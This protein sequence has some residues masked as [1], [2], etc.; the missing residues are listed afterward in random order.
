MDDSHHHHHQAPAGG[1]AG[2]GPSDDVRSAHVFTGYPQHH[3]YPS[4]ASNSSG[5]MPPMSHHQGGHDGGHP[6]HG[7]H[8]SSA[9][10]AAASSSGR[11]QSRDLDNPAGLFPD[12]P[13]DKKRKF[14]L[15]E[16]NKRNC[17]LRVRVTLE[18]VDTKEIPDSFRK[19]SSVFPRS[20]FPREM[21][22]PPPSATG[23]RFFQD[24]LSDNEAED[25]NEAMEV[26]GGRTGRSRG[27]NTRSD[28]V[29][30]KVPLAG[31]AEGEV[32]IPRTRRAARQSEVKLNDLGYRMAW[33]QSRVFAGRTVFL[34]KALDNYRTKT[35]TAIET[36][37]G[38]DAEIDPSHY[39]MRPGKRRWTERMRRSEKPEDDE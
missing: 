16:D 13:A 24:D 11:R 1:P 36:V 15:V 25:D 12:L 37:H 14:I 6:H 38:P 39:V 20:Y 9:V 28:R 30:V 19:S 7:G 22:S 35:R 33:L 2:S 32:A 3:P 26:E 5:P 27:K 17:R 4:S 21:Q 10:A 8:H 18:N 29:M 23:S 34:Q 31:G